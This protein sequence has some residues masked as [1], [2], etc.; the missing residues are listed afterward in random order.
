[1]KKEIILRWIKKAEEDLRIAKHL[2]EI[3][4]PPT[5]GICFHCQQ[6]I[7]K[8]LKGYLT[9]FDIRAMK[10][11]DLDKIMDLCIEKDNDFESLDRDKISSLGFYAVEVRY[12][13]EFYIPTIEETKQ[14]FDIALEVRDF[15]LK[16]LEVSEVDL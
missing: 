4:Q 1:M 8:Y 5:G 3:E 9:Y 2:L 14:S 12:P 6:A 11:H 10:T 15:V 16:K 7:E 13:D